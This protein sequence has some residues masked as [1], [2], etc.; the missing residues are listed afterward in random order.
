MIVFCLEEGIM[1]RSEGLVV[2]VSQ[3]HL[4]GPVLEMYCQARSLRLGTCNIR[5]IREM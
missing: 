3:H 5:N 4:P 2:V 1:I